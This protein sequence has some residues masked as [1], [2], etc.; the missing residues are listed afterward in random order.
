MALF[1]FRL[2][3]ILRLREAD[4]DE[5]RAL[6]ADAQ[7]AEHVICERIAAIDRELAG[8]KEQTARASRPGRID[9]EWLMDVRRYE[10][11]L[12]ADR[13]AALEQRN[14]VEAEVARRREELVAAD[15]EVRML[16]KLRE[17][18]FQRHREDENRQ[19]VKQL[20]ETGIHGYYR[21]QR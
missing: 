10:L 6:L 16:E 3:T 9:V 14:T 8:T 18:Q 1:R 15:R 5:R 7:R 21:S 2:A 17:T 19:E 11:L 12:K 13:Q 4:R 20:D